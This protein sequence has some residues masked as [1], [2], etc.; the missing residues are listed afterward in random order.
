MPVCECTCMH[1]YLHMHT[2]ADMHG[3]KSER[4]GKE[5]T[6]QWVTDLNKRTFEERWGGKMT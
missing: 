3:V 2:F 6:V 5:E 4:T 1:V